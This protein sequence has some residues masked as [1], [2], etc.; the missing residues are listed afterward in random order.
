[1]WISWFRFALWRVFWSTLGSKSSPGFYWHFSV[2]VPAINRI[3]WGVFLLFWFHFIYF[4]YL[5]MTLTGIIFQVTNDLNWPTL[6]FHV[7]SSKVAKEAWDFF[8]LTG[9]TCL[10]S[11]ISHYPNFIFRNGTSRF[12][13]G[14]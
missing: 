13:L 2:K 6:W 8:P 14:R 10:I 3:L 1:M 12:Y 9:K 5:A 11:S 4:S 7:L